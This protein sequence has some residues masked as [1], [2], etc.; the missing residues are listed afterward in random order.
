MIWRPWSV[1][2]FHRTSNSVRFLRSEQKGKRRETKR[3]KERK[4]TERKKTERR[5]GELRE[6][7]RERREDMNR[8]RKQ[9]VR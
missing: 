4:K 1:K 7:C 5:N 3:G 6:R 8:K 2:G 9:E